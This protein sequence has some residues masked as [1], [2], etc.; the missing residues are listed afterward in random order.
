MP[1][2]ATSRKLVKAEKLSPRLAHSNPARQVRTAEAGV[3]RKKAAQLFTVIA[4]G[5]ALPV[6]KL[7]AEIIPDSSWKRSG[8]TLTPS[9]GE[10]TLRLER[11]LTLATAIW[12]EM[13]K[14]VQWLN[15]PHLQLQGATPYSLLRTESGGR[16]V[17][18]L[19]IALDH[20]F[21]V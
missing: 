18:D 7:R 11:V 8:E 2:A 19:L 20:G 6:G 17:E 12:G 13:Q 15:T 9:A 5:S 14:A 10:S 1:Q 21:P 16:Q 3:P 4:R